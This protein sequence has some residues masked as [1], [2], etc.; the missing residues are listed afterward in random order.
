MR[1]GEM[2]SYSVW[3]ISGSFFFGWGVS[4]M[5]VLIML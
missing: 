4:G 2:P 3:T 5:K 1:F